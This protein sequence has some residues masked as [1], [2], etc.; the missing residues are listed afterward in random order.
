MSH[1]EKLAS[2]YLFWHDERPASFADGVLAG[3]FAATT[4]P[5]GGARL[6]NMPT[7]AIVQPWHISK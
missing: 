3:L 2:D 1:S 6:R 4:A 5:S 7:A